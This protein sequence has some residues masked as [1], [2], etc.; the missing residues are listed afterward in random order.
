MPDLLWLLIVSSG[1]LSASGSRGGG[2]HGFLV[3]NFPV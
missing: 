2:L 3:C 1:F